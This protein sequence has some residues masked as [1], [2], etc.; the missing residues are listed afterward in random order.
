MK[1]LMASGRPKSVATERRD[2]TPLSFGKYK[3][4]TPNQV[5]AQDPEYVCWMY[6]NVKPVPC[7]KEL[8][9]DCQFDSDDRAAGEEYHDIG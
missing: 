8:A 2:I 4:L 9:L 1:S 3:G 6:E 7:T 5:A